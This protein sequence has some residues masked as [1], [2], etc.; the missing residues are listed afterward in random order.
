[1][2]EMRNFVKSKVFFWGC[3]IALFFSIVAYF[4]PRVLF[5]SVL[6]GVFLGVFVAVA[7]V[8]TP[9][10]WASIGKGRLDRVS[11]LV[12]GI[13]LLWVSVAGQ[14]IYWLVWQANGLPQSWQFNQLL[15]GLILLSIIGGGLFVTAPGFPANDIDAAG[16]WG[17]NRK[18]LLWLGALGGLITFVISV[19]SGYSL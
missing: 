16:V 11:Q 17:S 7:I 4:T 10:I 9:L 13:A 12:I 3:V 8:Y 2:A 15:S 6:N 19:S 5:T 14:R 1:M 18:L